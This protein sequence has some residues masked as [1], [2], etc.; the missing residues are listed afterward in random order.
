LPVIFSLFLAIATLAGASNAARP[1]MRYVH[2]A[3]ES[4]SD[5]RYQYQWE[6]LR[7][8]LE[9]TKASDGP[10]EMV[11]SAPMTEQRQTDEMLAG[12]GTLNVMY[13]GTKPDL[14]QRLWPVRIP[15]DRNLGGYSILMARKETVERLKAVRSLAD[16]RPFS[17]GEGLGWLDVAILRHNGFT[18]VTGSSYDGLFQMLDNRR[19]D[20]FPRAVVEVLDEYERVH[21]QMPDLVLDQRLILYYP[22]PMYFWFQPT[23]EGKRL[24]DRA[25]RGM[26]AMIEDGSFQRV[27]D[28]FQG[29]KIARLGLARRRLLKA[30]NPLLG[31]ETPFGDKRLWYRLSGQEERVP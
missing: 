24:A 2:N 6:V 14:E 8:A 26:L 22:L 12:S 15:V 21:P 25:R 18:V 4:A 5:I 10:Y 28:K 3:P 20:V 17:V 19:F 9:R 27:F 11:P 1:P 31:P 29:W 23:P 13:L 7:L 16:L 30:S